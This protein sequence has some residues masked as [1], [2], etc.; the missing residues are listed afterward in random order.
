VTDHS[1][2]VLHGWQNHR[3]TD[4][5]QHRL[6]DELTARGLVVRYPQLPDADAPDPEAWETAVRSELAALP[7]GPVAVVCHS[8]GSVL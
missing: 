1:F 3:P 6:A 2:L 4:H 8:L 5:W 7:D